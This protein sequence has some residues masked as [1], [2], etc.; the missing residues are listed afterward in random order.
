MRLGLAIAILFAA[1]AALCALAAA[2]FASPGRGGA[3]AHAQPAACPSSVP[4]VATQAA[5]QP[6]PVAAAVQSRVNM[7]E[8]GNAGLLPGSRR[9]LVLQATAT[10]SAAT[11]TVTPTAAASATAT[12]A[13]TPTATPVI[14]VPSFGGSGGA[15]GGGAIGGGIGGYGY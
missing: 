8:T 3:V 12:A 15:I 5:P 11:P 6:P 13:T 1:G 7:P 14:N 9:P 4:V 10:C 2:T